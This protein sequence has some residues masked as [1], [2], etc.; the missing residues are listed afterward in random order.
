MRDNIQNF[1]IGFLLLVSCADTELPAGLRSEPF[2]LVNPE[3]QNFVL[4][5]LAGKGIPHKIDEEGFIHFLLK[6]QSKVYSIERRALYGDEL[7]DDVWE[8][9]IVLGEDSRR[10]YPKA[11][12]EAGIPHR[13][14]EKDGVMEIEW[15][16]IYGPKVDQLRQEIDTAVLSK[17]VSESKES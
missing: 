6:D 4:R 16:Q 7:R 17:I 10:A 3:A 11:F 13:V 8:S 15:N 5:E 2:Y 12:A 1:L 14:H 9:E